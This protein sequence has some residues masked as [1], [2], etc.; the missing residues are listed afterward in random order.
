MQEERMAFIDMA[1]SFT[2]NQAN[3]MDVLDF[4]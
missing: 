3:P 4:Q 2:K 1:W